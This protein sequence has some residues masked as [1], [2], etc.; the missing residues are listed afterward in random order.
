VLGESD[1]L[2]MATDAANQQLAL[3]GIQECGWEGEGRREAGDYVWYGG[4][5]LQS[6]EPGH[7]N[8]YY[9]GAAVGVHKSLDAAVIKTV[10]KGGRVQLVMIRGAR[11]KRLVSAAYTPL[12]KGIVKR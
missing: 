3:C 2:I 1:L 8:R 12:R 10:H 5:A 11:G 7:R 4:G 9:G 6:T